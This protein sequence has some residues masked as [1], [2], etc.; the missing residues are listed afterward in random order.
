MV[1]SQFQTILPNKITPLR[2]HNHHKGNTIGF[3]F[4]LIK[5]NI[6]AI[7]KVSIEGRMRLEKLVSWL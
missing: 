7:A 2:S 3:G 5:I 4:G 1:N 6:Y